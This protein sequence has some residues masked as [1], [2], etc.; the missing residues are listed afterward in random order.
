MSELNH[1]FSRKKKK[2]NWSI[3]IVFVSV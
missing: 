3:V 2:K 1:N